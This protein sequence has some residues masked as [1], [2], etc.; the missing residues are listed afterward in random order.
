MGFWG[1]VGC[2]FWAFGGSLVLS[3]GSWVFRGADGGFVLDCLTCFVCSER[4]TN[5]YLSVNGQECVL[6]WKGKPFEPLNLGRRGGQSLPRV[7]KAFALPFLHHRDSFCLSVIELA[8]RPAG[9]PHEGH[10]SL[11][12]VSGSDAHLSRLRTSSL[13]IGHAL[14]QSNA[15]EGVLVALFGA[16]LS[17]SR[18]CSL[19]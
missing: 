13:R 16:M 1:S 2:S 19:R 17:R 4:K 6:L 5:L 15:P 9:L 7:R 14:P 3:W 18:F 11:S 12:A 10:L 8:F